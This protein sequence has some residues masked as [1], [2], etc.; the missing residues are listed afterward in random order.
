MTAR[1]WPW[2]R[3]APCAARIA[4]P[5]RRWPR[6][7][8]STASTTTSATPGQAAQ[9]AFEL[10]DRLE[11]ELS[12]FVAN[13][14]V[15][16]I[17]SL[18]AGQA[19][20]VSPSTME[21]LEIARRL[22]DLTGRAFDISIGSGLEAA[23]SR[24]G[25]VRRPRAGRRGPAG[26]GRHRQGLRGRPHGGAAGGV[27]GP[28]RP[29]PRGLQLGPGPRG[30]SGPGRM[31]PDP[32]RARARGRQ[33]PRPGLGAPGGLQRVRD[34]EGRPHPGPPHRP[35]RAGP[36]GLGGSL[37]PA[38]RRARDGRSPAAVAEGL[39]TAFM[40]LPVEEIAELCRREP[41]LEAWLVREPAEEG[42]GRRPSSTWPPRG[43][44]SDGSRRAARKKE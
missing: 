44:E 35:G 1:R 30:P 26:P 41:G 23:R 40:I 18:A 37:P 3:R 2:A 13:S 22:Y 43:P 8:R 27:G 31:A 32:E 24:P 11:R 38:E 42:A 28:P 19:T 12:R 7:S 39:S 21:C 25:R 9:A 14:D 10:V 36:G 34:A 33:G 5:T 17:N 16:R 6:C 15:S 4:S 20:R 29:R